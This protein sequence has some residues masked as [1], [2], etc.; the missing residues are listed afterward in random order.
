MGGLRLRNSGPLTQVSLPLRRSLVERIRGRLRKSLRQLS[1]SRVTYFTKQL[2]SVSVDRRDQIG[3]NFV[4]SCILRLNLRLIEGRR[5][6][7]P[8][9]STILLLKYPQK[10]ESFCNVRTHR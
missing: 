2:N 10:T 6:S 9:V 1:P 4:N 3:K 5:E 7:V 8:R